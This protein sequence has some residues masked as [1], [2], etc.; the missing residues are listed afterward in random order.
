MKHRWSGAGIGVVIA[1]ALLIAFGGIRY[2]GFLGSY[3]ILTVL[4][5]NSMFALVGL[6]MCFVIMTGGIDLSVGSVAAMASVVSAYLSPYGLLPGLLGGVGAGLVAG[7]LSGLIITKL[8]ILPFIATL[9]VMLA[10]SGTGLLL[11]NNQSVAVSYDSAFTT[12]GQGN[13]LAAFK[14][15]WIDGDNAGWMGTALGLFFNFP[16]PAWIALVAYIVGS[17]VL[18]ARPFGRHVLA[19]G[20]GEEASRLMGLPTDRTVFAVYLISGGLAGLAGVILAAQFGAGQP[21]EGIGWELFAIASVVVGGTLL[22]GGKGSVFTTLAGVLLL[23]LIFTILN[24]ENGMGWISLS[25]YWQSVVRGAF[26][27]VVVILQS[28]LA[29]TAPA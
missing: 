4:R 20:G 28:R 25:A 11:A 3:N 27:L 1:L 22:T 14:P 16:T 8:K 29:R 18:N 6:G 12:L 7:T 9:A 13:L 17:V 23:G 21:I 10:A 5:Y 19:V 15:E 24:F 2:D 26:L